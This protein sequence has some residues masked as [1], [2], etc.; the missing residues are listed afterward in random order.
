VA[1]YKFIYLL[2]Y[3]L[4]NRE[5]LYHDTYLLDTF[6]DAGGDNSMVA[7]ACSVVSKWLWTAFFL[8]V[9]TPVF[10]LVRFCNEDI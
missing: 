4:F 6:F 5:F 9:F 1:P 8:P 10:V 7:V 2:T 3:L